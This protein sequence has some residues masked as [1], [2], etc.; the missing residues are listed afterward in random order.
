MR[1]RKLIKDNQKNF[2]RLHMLIDVFVIAASYALVQLGVLI[3]SSIASEM[4]V[5]SE[6]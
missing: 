5:P 2:S 4:A 1:W 6:P 3:A